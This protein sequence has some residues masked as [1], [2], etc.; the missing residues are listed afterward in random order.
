MGCYHGK[1]R[2][3]YLE[4]NFAGRGQGV[5]RGILVDF[6]NGLIVYQPLPYFQSYGATSKRPM[7]IAARLAPQKQVSADQPRDLPNRRQAIHVDT[8]PSISNFL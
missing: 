5:A 3:F 4:V 8:G 7:L 6:L 1:L 2:P